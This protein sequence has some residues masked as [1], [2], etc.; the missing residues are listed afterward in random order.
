MK[1]KVL[2]CL[3]IVPLIGMAE[4]YEQLTIEGHE[5]LT[6]EEGE[7]L[8]IENDESLTEET[9]KP[10]TL[11]AVED[12]N[13]PFA[14]SLK[15]KRVYTEV[16]LGNGLGA[17]NNTN[18]FL[19]VSQVDSGVTPNEWGEAYELNFDNLHHFTLADEDYSIGAA[20]G[21]ELF[22]SKESSSRSLTKGEGEGIT[23]GYIDILPINGEV[24][25][26]AVFSFPGTG[27]ANYRYEAEFRR[28]YM[29]LSATREINPNFKISG[30]LYSSLSKLTLDSDVFSPSEI[31]DRGRIS[32]D[33][34]VDSYS[35]GPSVRLQTNRQIDEKFHVFLDAKVGILFS[36]GK[37]EATQES[38]SEED[39]E[40]DGVAGLRKTDD[41]SEDFAIFCGLESGLIFQINESSG[42]TVSVGAEYR[43]DSYEIINPRSSVGTEVDDP[44]FFGG[45]SSYVEQVDQVNLYGGIEYTHV[46]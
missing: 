10:L 12:N 6:I 42:V 13:Q 11:D 36:Y 30:S 7:Q 4:E 20:F 35:L 3:L 15:F 40:P 34:R 1:I 43:N 21:M 44:A 45:T 46:F 25:P 41:R 23:N 22:E 29:D 18:E 14:V 19:F 39:P 5:Q 27:S 31:D 38:V 28:L 24:S 33:Q 32:L 8:I 17:V 9:E 16:N 2:V 26:G 37:M